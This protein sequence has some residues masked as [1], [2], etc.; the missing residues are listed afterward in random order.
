MLEQAIER[1]TLEVVKLREAVERQTMALERHPVTN[2]TV[3][4]AAVPGGQHAYL[5]ER[6]VAEL[7]GLS[8][9]TVRRWRLFRQGPPYRKLG[10]A[11]RYSR[12][13]LLAWMDEQ[14]PG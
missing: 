9:G 12:A 6:A 13:E 7:C 4:S 14:Q 3:I 1:L 10:S 2:T 11:V 8:V 5:T